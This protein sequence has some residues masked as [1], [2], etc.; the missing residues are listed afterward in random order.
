[1]RLSKL[2]KYILLQCLADPKKK[3][4]R[5]QLL[6]FYDNRRKKPQR[7]EMIDSLTKS[8]DRLIDRGLM[9]GYGQRTP[10]KWYLKEIKLTVPGRKVAKK[11][12]GEQ[13]FLPF[14]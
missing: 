10:R 2:Q 5:D 4:P 11:Y 14:K 6:Q 8:L 7:K 1:M 9:I 13:Q 3:F 12:L